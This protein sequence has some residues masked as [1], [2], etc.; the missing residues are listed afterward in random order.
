MVSKLQGAAQ[1]CM[2]S[3][4]SHRSNDSLNTV[5]STSRSGKNSSPDSISIPTKTAD[6][7]LEASDKSTGDHPTTLH[8]KSLSESQTDSTSMSV[9]D[10]TILFSVKDLVVV[11]TGGGT[12]TYSLSRSSF[13][14]ETCHSCISRYRSDDRQSTRKQWCDR[15]Y[16]GKKRGNPPQ[17]RFR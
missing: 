10:R 16:C 8:T 14:N 13:S 17:S 9:L 15:L 4:R 7:M 12:G 5:P 3:I 2:R 6:A 1:A 11:V